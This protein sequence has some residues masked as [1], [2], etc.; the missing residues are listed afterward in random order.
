[1]S[2]LS[3]FGTFPT[4]YQFGLG[5]FQKYP[6]ATGATWKLRAAIV[7]LMPRAASR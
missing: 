5:T 2:K 4:S 1:V 7:I 6:K 3:T